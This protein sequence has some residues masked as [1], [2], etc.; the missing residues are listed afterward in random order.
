MLEKAMKRDEVLLDGPSGDDVC[1][2]QD[3]PKALQSTV[4]VSVCFSHLNG[5]RRSD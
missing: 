5:A 1:G 2:V 3:Q 4:N